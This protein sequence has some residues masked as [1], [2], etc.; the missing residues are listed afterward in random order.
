LRW[1][2][3]TKAAETDDNAWLRQLLAGSRE[4]PISTL[5]AAA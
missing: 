2:G 4:G 5:T 3:S 1:H